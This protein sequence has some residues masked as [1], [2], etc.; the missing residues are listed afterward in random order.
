MSLEVV[1]NVSLE[2]MYAE[3]EAMSTVSAVK[4]L[5]KSTDMSETMRGAMLNYID[6]IEERVGVM[7]RIADEERT[8]LL[9]EM[10]RMRR[11]GQ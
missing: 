7:E 4:S 3:W 8:K 11:R 1:S 9:E 6:E 10:R 5:V 2:I